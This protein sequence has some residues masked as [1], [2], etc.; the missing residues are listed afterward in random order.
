MVIEK[1]IKNLYKT[2][3]FKHKHNIFTEEVKKVALSA[4]D[5]NRTQLI[6]LIETYA[7]R[8]SKDL[9]CKKEET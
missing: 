6:D 8:T 4:N 7:Y 3:R 1:N 9:V 2:N 5:Y